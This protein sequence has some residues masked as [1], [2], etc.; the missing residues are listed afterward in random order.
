MNKTKKIIDILIVEDSD[1]DA[2]LLEKALSTHH[3]ENQEFTY[4][5]ARSLDE[6]RKLVEIKKFDVIIL[7]LSLPDSDGI[8]TLKKVREY[9]G[10]I[11]IVVMSDL[12]NEEIA[13][14]SVREGA[15]EYLIKGHTDLRD[16]HYFISE[17]IEREHLE[18]EL[19]LA[20]HEADEA[21]RLKDKFVSLVMHDLTTSLAVFEGTLGV[22]NDDQGDPLT[23]RQKKFV[24]MLLGNAE[25]MLLM[26]NDLLSMSRVDAGSVRPEMRFVDLGVITDR[27]ITRFVGEARRKRINLV[28]ETPKEQRVYADPRLL[29]VVIKNLLSNAIK[30][31]QE[32][33]TV[34]IKDGTGHNYTLA[35]SDSGI[36]IDKDELPNIFTE[37]IKTVR[38]GTS[39]EIGAGLGL[40]FSHKIMT[41]LGGRLEVKS[42]PGKGSVFFVQLPQV[43]PKVLVVDDDEM[44]REVY[45]HVLAELNVDI[46]GAVDGESAIQKIKKDVFHLI[47]ID[48]MMPG[49]GG[50]KLL[51]IIKS[52][53]R[54]KFIPVVM[55]T[56]DNEISHKEQG[57]RAG[58][59]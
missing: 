12:D 46:S 35:V 11:P 39:G 43:K 32:G 18:E 54:A 1:S 15:Q 13:I 37:E 8:E 47:T 14:Q 31:S 48:I 56:S 58:R 36:G 45:K 6:T 49:M 55:V 34:T 51:E 7:D 23:P 52:H 28:D 33:R 3:A 42:A 53:P 41:S 22:L 50:F 29:E 40:P 25:D 2:S 30:Y 26:T 17:A 5:R 16:L 4:T 44:T 9:A 24:E 38:K 57:V 20:K 21:T 27:A 10:E 19:K 59:R